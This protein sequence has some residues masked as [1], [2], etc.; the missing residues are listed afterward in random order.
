MSLQ[1]SARRLLA[2]LKRQREAAHS[3]FAPTVPRPPAAPPS[4]PWRFFSLPLPWRPAPSRGSA[5]SLPARRRPASPAPQAQ[6]PRAAEKKTTG[7]PRRLPRRRPCPCHRQRK[8]R[9]A[10]QMRRRCRSSSTRPSTWVSPAAATA[11]AADGLNCK[12]TQPSSTD[13]SLVSLLRSPAAA[14]AAP[15]LRLWTMLCGGLCERA[16]TSTCSLVRLPRPFHRATALAVLLCTLAPSPFRC[17]PLDPRP[18]I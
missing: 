14:P 1:R 9:R 10:P 13:A 4:R 18:P 8:S 12:T 6:A 3:H 7:P 17:S 11:A 2:P 15:A 16:R 5:S